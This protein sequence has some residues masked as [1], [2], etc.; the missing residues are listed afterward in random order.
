MPC[1]IGFGDGLG[2]VSRWGLREAFVL[3]RVGLATLRG[4]PSSG[5]SDNGEAISPARGRRGRSQ[6][7]LDGNG[8]GKVESTVFKRNP[9]PA[10]AEAVAG[11]AGTTSSRPASS[12]PTSSGSR[13]R[14]SRPRSSSPCSP[15]SMSWSSGSNSGTMPWTRPWAWAWATTSPTS[16]RPR[17]WRR[18][19]LESRCGPGPRHPVRAG[20]GAARER[21]S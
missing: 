18:G 20:P 16:Y 13:T 7:T 1:P 14:A 9:L 21:R 19:I 10:F 11:P 5:L 17:R 12:P 3:R 8:S 15:G 4:G 6:L 2:R